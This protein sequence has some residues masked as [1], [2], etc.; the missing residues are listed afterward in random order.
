V[1]GRLLKKSFLESSVIFY[2]NFRTN[3]NA[4]DCNIEIAGVQYGEVVDLSWTISLFVKNV[5]RMA[6]VNLN[7]LK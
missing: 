6:G 7:L 4:L 3:M 1:L 5:P 2:S